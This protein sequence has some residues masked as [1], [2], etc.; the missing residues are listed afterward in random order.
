MAADTIKEKL[1]YLKLKQKDKDAFVK[2]YD[3]YFDDIYRFVFFKVR[4]K[5]DAEDLTSQVFLKTWDH[6]RNNTLTDF[7]TLRSLFYKVAR[8]LVIDHYR[9]KSTHN[10]SSIE[11][12]ENELP[13]VDAAKE[14]VNKMDIDSKYEFIEL[15]LSELKDEYREII[16]MRYINELSVS[17]ISLIL[18]KTKG[19]TRVL[20]YRA[21]N[22]LKKITEK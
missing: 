1:L 22:A 3:L 16:I 21:L 10:V 15:K 20:V 6:I 18:D 17:E 7:K 4:S 12:S 19:N 13:T 14:I 11:E 8:N 9:K 2:A 5:E